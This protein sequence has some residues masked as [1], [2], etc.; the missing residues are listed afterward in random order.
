MNILSEAETGVWRAGGV[1]VPEFR[2]P[3]DRLERLQSLAARPIADNPHMGDDPIA[4]PRVP[5]SGVQNVMRRVPAEPGLAVLP[6]R[7]GAKRHR[8]DDP[9]GRSQP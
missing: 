2:L 1:V 7:H 3:P 4:S 5:G 6:E 9:V 8:A